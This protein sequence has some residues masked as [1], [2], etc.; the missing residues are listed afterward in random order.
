MDAAAAAAAAASCGGAPPSQVHLAVE[1]AQCQ[2]VCEREEDNVGCI[3]VVKQRVVEGNSLNRESCKLL[4][5]EGEDGCVAVKAFYKTHVE[6]ADD[7][8]SGN[9]HAAPAFNV[10]RRA[11]QAC[12]VIVD[13]HT[14]RH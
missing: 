14:T 11:T 6:V 12:V 7:T 13:F 2:R 1:T 8:V 5:G 4:G 3:K 10:K 9:A